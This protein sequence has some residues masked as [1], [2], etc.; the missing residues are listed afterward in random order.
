MLTVLSPGELPGVPAVRYR[1]TD[2]A[3]FHELWEGAKQ[4]QGECVTESD[5]FGTRGRDGIVGSRHGVEAGWVAEGE[6]FMCC[7]VLSVRRVTML[8]VRVSRIGGR[9]SIGVFLWSARS[10]IDIKFFPGLPLLHGMGNWSDT[11]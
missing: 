6:S 9:G 3:S 2:V 5:D 8:K 11:A 7:S 4:V 1:D 10:P